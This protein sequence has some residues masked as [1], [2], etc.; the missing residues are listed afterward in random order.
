MDV[1]HVTSSYANVFG[2]KEVFY[3]RK[4]PQSNVLGWDAIETSCENALYSSR[5]SKLVEKTPGLL[6]LSKLIIR[7]LCK[8]LNPF[9]NCNFRFYPGFDVTPIF[10]VK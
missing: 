1:T 8:P 6:R 9:L 10:L 2:A 3:M 4:L 7:N 5:D